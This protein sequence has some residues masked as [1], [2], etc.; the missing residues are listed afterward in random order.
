MTNY[1]DDPASEDESGEH[2]AGTA[3]SYAPSAEDVK[4]RLRAARRSGP[5]RP[6]YQLAAAEAA[7]NTRSAALTKLSSVSL[8]DK[9]LLAH[10]LSRSVDTSGVPRTL[11]PKLRR[12]VL[13]LYLALG[14]KN[15][16]E[17]ILDRLTVAAANNALNSYARAATANP[18]ALDIHLRHAAKGTQLVINLVEAKSRLRDRNRRT[19]RNLKIE[20]GGRTTVGNG[21]HCSK[22]STEDEDADA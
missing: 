18:K 17:S 4:D 19:V 7:L 2:Q 20:A 1:I 5:D 11:E 10:Q 8:P 9:D 22:S 16:T 12:D 21:K 15:P 14:S 6:F 13:Q 3:K